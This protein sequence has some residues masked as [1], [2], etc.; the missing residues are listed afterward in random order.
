MT[1]PSDSPRTDAVDDSG[2]VTARF[3][4]QLERDLT[5]AQRDAARLTDEA[6]RRAVVGHELMSAC[7]RVL[8]HIPDSV[9]EQHLREAIHTYMEAMKPA[10]TAAIANKGVV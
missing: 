10:Y 8:P 5:A 7:K 2:M 1:T 3:A 4:R 9:Y 6:V